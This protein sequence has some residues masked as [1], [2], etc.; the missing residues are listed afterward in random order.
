MTPW[1]V[2][3]IIFTL[4][5]FAMVKI[6]EEIE[7]KSLG[8]LF[9]LFTAIST[10]QITLSTNLIFSALVSCF[11][12]G[13]LYYFLRCLKKDSVINFFILALLMS[14]AITVH[15]QAIPLLI[16]LVIAWAKKR[17]KPKYLFYSIG[18]FIIPFI[19]LIIFDTQTGFY[20]STHL[21][22]FFLFNH[23]AYITKRWLIYAGQFWP[24]VWGDIIGGNLFIGALLMVI[25]FGI[26]AYQIGKKQLNREMGY[27]LIAFAGIFIL[28]RYFRGI[29]FE[30]FLSFLHPF[31][32]LI[33]AWVCLQIYKMH[34]II[35]FCFIL[36]IVV[37]T[38][39]NSLNAILHSTNNTD[40]ETQILENVIETKYPNKTYALYDFQYKNT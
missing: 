30:G 11:S 40:K 1:I 20:E 31:V 21:V 18:G 32:L 5:V 26:A 12:V 17:M 6:G 10:A 8:L 25:S 2:Q 38:M 33:S 22:Q 24:D 29:L 27:S 15:F 34:R 7:Q 28:L 37:L 35:G 9:G 13:C 39:V 23:D 3:S 4:M 14:V 36:L 16:L 19:P